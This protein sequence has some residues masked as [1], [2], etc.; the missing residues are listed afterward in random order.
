MMLRSYYKKDYAPR[1]LN[2]NLMNP[3]LGYFHN[4]NVF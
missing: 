1:D 4:L 2:S 3:I